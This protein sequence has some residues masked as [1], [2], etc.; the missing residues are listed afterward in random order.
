M[1]WDAQQLEALYANVYRRRMECPVC[2][3]ALK[4][5][6]SRELGA[7]GDVECRACDAR[8]FVAVANDPLRYTFR[9]Y[10]EQENREVFAAERKRQAPIC[11][12]DGTEM[13]VHL[14]RSLGRTSNATIRCRR[15]ARTAEYVRTHG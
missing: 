14:Q 3:G 9:A 13:D 2:G 6:P 15:C 1:E 12:V 4:F 7:V 5:V 10:T 8:H 11:P